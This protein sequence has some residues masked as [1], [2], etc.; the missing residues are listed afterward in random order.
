MK[1]EQLGNSGISVSKVGMGTFEIGGTALWGDVNDEN[2]I[3]SIKKA[4]ELGVTFFDTA[5]AYGFGRSETVLGKA[6]KEF[7]HDVVVSTKIGLTTEPTGAYVYSQSNRMI[8]NDLSKDGLK[9]QIHSSL[10]NLGTDYID[11]LT[12]HRHMETVNTPIEEVSDCLKDF[13]K[14]GLVRAV[15][16]SNLNLK[17]TKEYYNN[18]GNALCAC[19]S[20]YNVLEQNEHPTEIE[21]FC[22]ENSISCIAING[23]ALGALTGAFDDDYTPKYGTERYASKWFQNGN[24]KTVNALLRKWRHYVHESGDVSAAALCLAYIL[25]KGICSHALAG[26][27]LPEHIIQNSKA[28]DITLSDEQILEMEND[29]MVFEK[30]SHEMFE[31]LKKQIDEIRDGKEKVVIWGAGAVANKLCPKLGVDRCDIIGIVDSDRNRIGNALFGNAIE[32]FENLKTMCQNADCLVICVPMTRYELK[33]IL[34]K[35]NIAEKKLV[36]VGELKW[37]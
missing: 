36:F 30:K 34:K 3:L 33:E 23:L 19:Q 7:R 21:R 31:S 6:I 20:F 25:N 8:Y 12:I 13:I 29:V 32:P 15:A 11:V 24:L 5:P 35:E 18:L 9:K 2:S 28:S 17:Q 14:Q 16:I 10:R 1:Y 27:S 26:A 37:A 4:Y 22:S